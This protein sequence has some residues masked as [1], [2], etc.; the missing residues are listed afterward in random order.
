MVSQSQESE[1]AYVLVVLYQW[2]VGV[3]MWG[4]LWLVE[5]PKNQVKMCMY[6]SF[7]VINSFIRSEYLYS[8]P[9]RY[10][11]MVITRLQMLVK[12]RYCIQITWLEEQITYRYCSNVYI[13][14]ILIKHT[15]CNYCLTLFAVV[16]SSFELSARFYQ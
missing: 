9:P 16:R 11:L 10:Q 15:T 13:Q 4:L 5:H 6:V 12:Y 7:I 14:N 3:C 8:T 1:A 2:S